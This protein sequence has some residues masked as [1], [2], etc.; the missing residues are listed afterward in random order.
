[1]IAF[2]ATS[3]PPGMG[4]RRISPRNSMR[5]G[6]LS[7]SVLS[8]GLVS[9][10]PAY[11]EAPHSIGQCCNEATHIVL[12]EVTRVSKDKNLILFKKLQDLKGQHP[13]AEI[14]HNIG[15]R[16]HHPREWQA[17]MK[18]AE[19]GKKAVFFHN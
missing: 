2:P 7:L 15:Q 3:R 1:M 18:W 6:V 11:V 8:F 14:K 12:M 17:V 16:G 4:R 10:A 19:V 9:S 5:T 13:Q